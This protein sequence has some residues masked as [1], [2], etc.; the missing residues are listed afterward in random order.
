ML[1]SRTG[2][3]SVKA[4]PQASEVE[5]LQEEFARHDAI[6]RAISEPGTLENAVAKAAFDRINLFVDDLQL[7]PSVAEIA[8]QVQPGPL[9]AL[10]HVPAAAWHSVA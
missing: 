1:V 9:S 6:L 10:Q 2:A 4:E 3:D 5:Y 8:H 7:T